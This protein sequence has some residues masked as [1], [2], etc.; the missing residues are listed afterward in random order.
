MEYLDTHDVVAGK[1][2][3]CSKSFKTKRNLKHTNN[4]ASSSVQHGLISK[5]NAKTPLDSAR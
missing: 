1:E 5:P 3:P 4:T 2:Q